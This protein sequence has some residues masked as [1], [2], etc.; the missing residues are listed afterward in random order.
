MNIKHEIIDIEWEGSFKIKYDRNKDKYNLDNVPSELLDECGF[1]QIYGRHPVY[2]KDVLLYIGET[3][4]S[5][6]SNRSFRVRLN[7]H[8]KGNFFQHTNIS[9][10]LGPCSLPAETVEIVESI[11]IYSHVPALNVQH[12]G[13]MKLGSEKYLVRNWGFTGN[14]NNA[15]TGNWDSD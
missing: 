11:L 3:K 4:E 5:K 13:S 12:T 7:E 9:V 1:Y 14:L 10:H 6:T 15:C 8:L 2:G